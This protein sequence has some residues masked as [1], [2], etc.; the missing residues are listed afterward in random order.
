MEVEETE[1]VSRFLK[2]T[3]NTSMLLKCCK[4]FFSAQELKLLSL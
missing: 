2:T 3:E 4:G 1:N